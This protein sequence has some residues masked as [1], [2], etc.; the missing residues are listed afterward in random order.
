MLLSNTRYRS[1]YQTEA[2]RK[3]ETLMHIQTFHALPRNPVFAVIAINLLIL[4][5]TLL[6]PCLINRADAA[7]SSFSDN[8]VGYR[9]GTKFKE[10]AT[11]NGDDIQKN[12]V[13]FTHFNADASGSHFFTADLLFSTSDDPEKDTTRGARE[14]YAI[15]RRDFSLSKMMGRDFSKLKLIRDIAL[16]LGGDMNAKDNTFDPRKRLLVMGPALQFALPAG[17]FNLAFDYSKEWNHNG[18]VNKDVSFN[19]AFEMEAVWG[20]PFQLGNASWQFNGFFNYVAPKGRDGFGVETKSEI[21]TRP[22][23]LLNVGE[24]FGKKNRFELG[25]GYEYWRNKFGNDHT[26]VVGS[27]AKTAMLIAKVHF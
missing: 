23:L 12:I 9:Y 14:I 16:H 18:I 4:A 13:S 2:M 11:A 26:Q 20:I 27:L 17:Y 15:Y 7:D 10:P 8:Y 3:G 19:P 21:L 5:A 6:A 24:L 22:E 1:F 25:M